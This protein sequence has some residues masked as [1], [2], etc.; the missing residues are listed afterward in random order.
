MTH[1]PVLEDLYRDIA[2][3]LEAV[4]AEIR[5]ALSSDDP[6]IAELTAHAA[7][8]GGKRLR[9]ATALLVARAAGGVG[10]LHA[11]LGAVVELIHLAT[12]VHDDVIDE[13][14]RRRGQSTV[15]A[16]WGNYEAVLLGDIIF[17]RAINLLA[18]IGDA[19]CLDVL[20]R[21]TSRLCEGEILQNRHR[22]DAG[23]TEAQ[24]YR[25]IGDKTAELYASG[26]GLSAH[27]AGASEDVVAG[28]R[29]YGFELGVAFQIIDDGLDLTGDEATVG[30]SLGTDL[31]LGKMT[32]PL[33][34]WRDRGGSEARRLLDRVIGRGDAGPAD[35]AAILDHLRSGGFL[36]AA[37]A[38]AAAHVAR[39]LDAARSVLAP[40][41]A[42]ALETVGHFVL[43]RTL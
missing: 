19:R 6:V 10:P 28:L 35:R 31:S 13:A 2:P 30:K 20:T 18:R 3:S 5:A 32:L 43:R 7:R 39:G 41:D 25:I 33:I 34:L 24:Y 36:E 42:A 8:Y 12:L 16:A 29:T 11:R 4:D 23:L 40:A 22:R 37:G 9:P 26:S 15:N 38:R 14:G 27:L 17:A 21:A 1:T